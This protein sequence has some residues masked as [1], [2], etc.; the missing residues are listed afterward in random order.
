ME[1]DGVSS[2]VDLT[3]TTSSV[4]RLF[5]CLASAAWSLGTFVLQLPTVASDVGMAVC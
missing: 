3:A 2:G 1:S 5:S 4:A